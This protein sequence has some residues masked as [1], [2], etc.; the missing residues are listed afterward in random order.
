VGVKI[1]IPEISAAFFEV[2]SV[3]NTVNPVFFIDRLGDFGG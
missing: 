2:E 1:Q 3:L